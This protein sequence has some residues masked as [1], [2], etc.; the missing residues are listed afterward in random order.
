MYGSLSHCWPCAGPGAP[1]C[2]GQEVH[3]QA[4]EE[5]AHGQE[6]GGTKVLI[7]ELGIFTEWAT[8]SIQSKRCDVRLQIFCCPLLE[9]LFPGGL[10]TSGQR[11]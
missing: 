7:R 5:A 1:H 4:A 3:L 8:R 11:K 9:I 10:E 2:Q 6:T